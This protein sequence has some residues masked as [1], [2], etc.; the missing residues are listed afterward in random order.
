MW[1]STATTRRPICWSAACRT[2][3]R[4]CSAS[5]CRGWWGSAAKVMLAWMAVPPSTGVSST[6]HGPG[7]GD[8]VGGPSQQFGGTVL[9]DPQF[10]GGVVEGQDPAQVHLGADGSHDVPGQVVTAGLFGGAQGGGGLLQGGQTLQACRRVRAPGG[11]GVRCAVGVC[12][13]PDLG[14][15]APAGE[16]LFA[17]GIEV[18]GALRGAAGLP[19]SGGGWVYRHGDISCA[20]V[21]RARWR[22]PRTLCSLMPVTCAISS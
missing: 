19:A 14:E 9:G 13:L 7:S 2:A 12:V 17:V 3:V 15:G 20:R 18:S 6:A 4:T 11:M 10:E 16:G 21:R 22:R 1:M 5:G 8:V